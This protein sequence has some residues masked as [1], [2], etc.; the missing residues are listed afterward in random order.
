MTDLPEP[1]DGLTCGPCKQWRCY[2][3]EGGACW[4]ECP[5]D[6]DLP[7]PTPTAEEAGQ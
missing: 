5:D 6:S 4:H 3:C 2:E 1:D 7:T